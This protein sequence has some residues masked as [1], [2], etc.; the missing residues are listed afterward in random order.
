MKKVINYFK[1]HPVIT[2]LFI[3][4]HVPLFVKLH[5]L[6]F[7]TGMFFIFIVLF[8]KKLLPRYVKNNVDRSKFTI[9]KTQR[10]SMR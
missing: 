5:G 2:S 8:M 1:K 7:G 4:A 3:T 10:D 6:L 9:K